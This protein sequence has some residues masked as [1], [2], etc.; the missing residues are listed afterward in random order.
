MT[1]TRNIA[2]LSLLFF[3][4]ALFTACEPRDLV[5][6]RQGCDYHD[7]NG[8][9]VDKTKAYNCW[10]ESAEMGYAPAQ[11]HLG[12]CYAFGEG[13]EKDAEEAVKWYTKAAQQRDDKAQFRL[14]V[15]YYNGEGVGKDLKEAVKWYR[16]AAQ[17]GNEDAINA[18]KELNVN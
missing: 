17:L 5:L 4:V 16:E 1:S 3:A 2:T 10:K 11:Y 7:G 12:E 18:L 13:V 14:A 15:C 8:V 9:S 6:F